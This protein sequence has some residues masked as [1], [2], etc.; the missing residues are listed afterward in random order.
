MNP[1]YV[2]GNLLILFGLAMLDV[3][4]VP[5]PRK[6]LERAARSDGG[7]YGAV[8]GMGALS[9]VVAAPCGAPAFAV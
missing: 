1:F 2:V 9:G 3:I 4:P 6:L 7:S 8:F 5:I